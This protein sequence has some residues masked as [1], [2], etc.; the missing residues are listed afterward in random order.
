MEKTCK[1]NINSSDINK[2]AGPELLTLTEEHCYPDDAFLV[3]LRP[4]Q[5]VR[6]ELLLSPTT[7]A[8]GTTPVS[9]CSPPIHHLSWFLFPL[10]DQTIIPVDTERM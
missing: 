5:Q 6:T 3:C 8:P 2:H 9:S 7:L 4:I 1:I 10:S